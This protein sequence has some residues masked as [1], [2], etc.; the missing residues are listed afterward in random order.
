MKKF[1]MKFAAKRLWAPEP[2][3]SPIDFIASK[4]D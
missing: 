4:A 2:K 1:M 3:E